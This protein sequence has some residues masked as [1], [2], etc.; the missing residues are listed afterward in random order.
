LRDFEEFSDVI[1]D[2]NPF[3]IEAVVGKGRNLYERR[4]AMA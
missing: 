1:A 3:I 4:L 2:Q